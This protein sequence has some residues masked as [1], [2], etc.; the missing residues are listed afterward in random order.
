MEPGIVASNLPALTM[1]VCSA[2]Y[3][4]NRAT[5][6]ECLAMGV[7]SLGLLAW[8]AADAARTVRVHNLAQSVSK[9]ERDAAAKLLLQNAQLLL[10]SNNKVPLLANKVRAILSAIAAVYGASFLYLD[11]LN[12]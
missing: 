6:Q 11:V 12:P 2:I 10:A 5:L 1:S 4:N 3:G 7:P 9:A 8:V